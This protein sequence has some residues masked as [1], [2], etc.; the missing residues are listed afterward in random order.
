VCRPRRRGDSTGHGR[1]RLVLHVIGF[2]AS[3]AALWLIGNIVLVIGLLF[4]V[5]PAHR[6][7]GASAE[8]LTWSNDVRSR[9]AHRPELR[10]TPGEFLRNQ[11][12]FVAPVA[13]RAG[14]RVV[15]SGDGSSSVT[16]RI[17]SADG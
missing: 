10:F 3:V 2:V 14:G 9:P 11:F 1:S 6:I 13:V 4:V 7:G 17:S 8:P 15:W 5:A 16:Q 12:W